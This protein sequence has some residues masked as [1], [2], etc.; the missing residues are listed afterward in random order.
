M[1]T[2]G[3]QES[4]GFP[5]QTPACVGWSLFFSKTWQQLTSKIR[6]SPEVLAT[7]VARVNIKPT[8]AFCTISQEIAQCVSTATGNNGSQL[9][10]PV[11]TLDI[12]V[13]SRPLLSVEMRKSLTLCSMFCLGSEFPSHNLK[14]PLC[15]TPSLGCLG[16]GRWSPAFRK[17][18]PW[19][20][21][22]NGRERPMRS[23]ME[24]GS[25]VERELFLF[26]TEELSSA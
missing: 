3:F 2:K 23:Y 13:A 14:W 9:Q 15:P 1:Q 16:M 5:S 19:Q 10:Q 22:R 6:S 20:A 12:P 24:I 17:S 8:T 7:A 26:P 11:V 4:T 25:R 21:C 18:A